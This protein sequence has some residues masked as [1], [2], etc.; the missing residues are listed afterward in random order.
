ML[1]NEQTRQSDDYHIASSKGVN[2]LADKDRDLRVIRTKRL[3][4]EA[5]MELLKEKGIS[6]LTVRDLT[7][8]AGINRGTFYLHYHDICELIE[9]TEMMKE[10]EEL[11]R[12][13]DFEAMLYNNTDQTPFGP[14]VRAFTHLSKHADFFRAIFDPKGSK[15]LGERLK[16]LM[17]THMY[18]HVKQSSGGATLGGIPD[19]YL[20]NYLG[21]AQ[22]GLIQTWLESGMA[23]TAEEMALMLTRLIQTGPLQSVALQEVD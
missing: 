6:G 20:I 14:I 1:I 22:F 18:D 9:R 8:R 19:R 21:A 17:G 15:A 4:D 7:Q 11:F 12:P 16:Y 5:F 10:L 2:L 3:I 23:F 13:A